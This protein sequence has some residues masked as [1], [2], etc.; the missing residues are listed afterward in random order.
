M[1]SFSERTLL[2]LLIFSCERM[3]I[4]FLTDFHFLNFLK[5]CNYFNSLNCL[6]S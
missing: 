5:N 2:I 3:V 6:R 1:K 4:H